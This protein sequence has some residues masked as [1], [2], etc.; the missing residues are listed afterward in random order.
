[1][2]R[3]FLS[4]QGGA[5]EEQGDGEEHETKFDEDGGVEE[6]L[7]VIGEAESRPLFMVRRVYFTP[8]KVEDGDEQRHNL[9]SLKIYDRRQGMSPYH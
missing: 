9:F 4:I 6:E 5:F 8:R 2:A 7:F 1:M 3:V